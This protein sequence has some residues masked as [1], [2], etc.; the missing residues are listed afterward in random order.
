MKIDEERNVEREEGWIGVLRK[1]TS[2]TEF[3]LQQRDGDKWRQRWEQRQRA[4]EKERA[5]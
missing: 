3:W 5:R 4:T 2:C 1:M